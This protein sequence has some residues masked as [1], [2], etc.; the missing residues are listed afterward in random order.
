LNTNLYTSISQ[1]EDVLCDW[2]ISR[3][4]VNR[5]LISWPSIR[6]HVKRTTTVD[7][8]LVDWLRLLQRRFASYVQHQLVASRLRRLRRLPH[9]VSTVSFEMVEMPR[10]GSWIG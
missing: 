8:Q 1:I 3:P 7:R 2:S 5:S 6:L 9:L 4:P 10:R